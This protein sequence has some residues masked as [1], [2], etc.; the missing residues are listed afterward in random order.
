MGYRSQVG[1]DKFVAEFFNFKKIGFFLDIGAHDGISLNNTYFLEKELDWKGICIEPGRKLF[2]KL[3]E[4][5]DC[6]CYNFAISNEDKR[7]EFHEESYSGCI[8]E[9]GDYEIDSLT[10]KSLLLLET[11]PMVIDYISLDI[12]GTE[13]D[14]LLGFPFE[15]HK[16]I[17]WTIEHNLYSTGATEKEKIKEIMLKNDYL[18]IRENVESEGLPFEDWY[19][20][21]DYVK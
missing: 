10:L 20:H 15:T 19:I 1:Q 3:L 11:F 14:A 9:N 12:E 4:K 13:Y 5:R 21:K 17:L 8:V 2:S 7:V 18:I 6:V 16:G